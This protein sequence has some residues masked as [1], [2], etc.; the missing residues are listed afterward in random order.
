MA[1]PDVGLRLRYWLEY[2]LARALF[3]LFGALPLDRASALGGWIGRN[4]GPR[5][6][7]FVLIA[8]TN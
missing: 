3:A 1:E 7:D 4:V 6:A 5:L 8:T 2:V